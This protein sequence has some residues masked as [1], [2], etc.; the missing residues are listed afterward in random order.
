MTA[1]SASNLPDT[2]QSAVDEQNGLWNWDPGMGTTFFPQLFLDQASL[3]SSDAFGHRLP[4]VPSSHVPE[5]GHEASHTALNLAVDSIDTANPTPS[6]GSPMTQARNIPSSLS[7][8]ARSQEPT[9][10][11]STG[12][13][14]PGSSVAGLPS[15]TAL[16]PTDQLEDLIRIFFSQYHI[17]LP[18]LHQNSFMSRVSRDRFLAQPNA[19][20]WAVLAVAANTHSNTTLQA[21]CLPW[22]SK[23]RE[24]FDASIKTLCHPTETL[25]AAV[26][27]IFQAYV[28]ADM[29]EMWVFL[30][31]ACRL[32]SLLGWDR[33]DSTRTVA[34]PFAPAPKDFQEKE[35]RRKTIWALFYLDRAMSSL[36]GW[37]VA[38]D[39]NL[40]MVN[41][42]I[43]DEAF[44]SSTPDVSSLDYVPKK[45]VGF[46]HLHL[47]DSWPSSGRALYNTFAD[48][49]SCNVI[50]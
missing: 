43:D 31:K 1:L 21:C 36:C 13:N 37:P 8:V 29:S 24:L 17:L 20:I 15:E 19:L 14:S 5:M 18:C 9:T 38:I 30:G 42:P 48:I 23:A 28:M 22:L 10:S 27:I 41:F 49:S 16:P 44:Q 2:L 33:V 35:E 32:A 47:K 34:S 45:F 46:H 25:Q 11:H 6:P 39:D 7:D 26:W 12:A 4:M 40:F 50:S 3:L